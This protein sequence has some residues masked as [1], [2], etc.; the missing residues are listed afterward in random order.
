MSELLNGRKLIEVRDS[1]V[2]GSEYV[3]T[4]HAFN[5]AYIQMAPN[6]SVFYKDRGGLI[7]LRG[8]QVVPFRI[9]LAGL[10]VS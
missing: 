10:P 5:I 4:L 3:F 2:T 8:I 6:V 1:Q 7:A 9:T